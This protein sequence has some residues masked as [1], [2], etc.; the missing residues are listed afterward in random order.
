MPSPPCCIPRWLSKWQSGTSRVWW[1]MPPPGNQWNLPLLG[2][3]KKDKQGRKSMEKVRVCIDPWMINKLIPDNDYSL[4]L[5]TDLFKK[6]QGFNLASSI[7]LEAGYN[8]IR[9]KAEDQHKLAFMW[10]GQQYMFQ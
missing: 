6:M 9:V 8:Q 2:V 3:C 7:D 4:P 5:I 1:C 10:N